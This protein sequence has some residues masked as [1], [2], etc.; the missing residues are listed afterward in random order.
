MYVEAHHLI[1]M[2]FQDLFS[3]S[4]DVEANVVSLCSICH[5]QIHH[6][7]MADKRMIITDLFNKRATRLSN[8]GISISLQQ[9]ISFYNGKV[10]IE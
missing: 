8:A 7:R 6:G 9:L 1:P 2:E 4:I 10:K 5:D 3:N